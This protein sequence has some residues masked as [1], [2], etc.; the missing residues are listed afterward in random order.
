MH[1]KN[2]TLKD[3]RCFDTLSIDLHYPLTV[4]VAENAG[5]KTSVLDGIAKGLA[6]WFTHLDSA[7]QRLPQFP[8]DDDDL[9]VTSAVNN[10][11]R[12]IAKLADATCLSLAMDDNGSPLNWDIIHVLNDSVVVH[13]KHGESSLKSRANRLR[14]AIHDGDDD[15]AIPVF[16]YY[17]I[18][19]G[20]V[21]QEIPDRIHEPNIDY[22][23]RLSS[24]VDALAPNLR[25]FSEM[26]RWFKE[27]SLDEL[28]WERDHGPGGKHEGADARYLGALPHVRRA[29]K[30]VFQDRVSDP[31]MDRVSKKFVV[32]FR[33]DDGK[34][35]P[36]RFDQLSQGYASVL[37]LVLDLAQR[38]AV[39]NPH[40]NAATKHDDQGRGDEILDPLSSP[41]IVLI[42]EVDLHL[43]PSWQQRVLGDLMNAFPRAQFIVT[44]H[45]PQVLTTVRSENIRV[46]GRDSDGRWQ[47]GPPL[48][49]PFARESKDALAYVMGVDP[50]PLKTD[51]QRKF[52][53]TLRSY[54]QI[55]RDGCK[56]SED[57]LRLRGEIDS[58]G[59]EIPAADLA[60]W[61]FLG[62]RKQD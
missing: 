9:R 33:G 14:D 34:I 11:G 28:Q 39:A 47:A 8:L 36:L 24:L 49:S 44:T 13:R 41:A 20:H 25:D 19:R 62:K 2:I 29:F 22:T 4:L 21:T 32:D 37:A 7:E 56:D 16:A 27:A 50:L 60:L 55:V 23:R 31:R 48:Q 43:H 61:E 54:E 6:A 5:G 59:Y 46:L 52:R 58:A 40:F 17:G 30:A 57:G 35:I 42:D 1:L 26:I 3:F 53:E 12:E 18:H 51:E 45:S 38:M 15:I 10:R